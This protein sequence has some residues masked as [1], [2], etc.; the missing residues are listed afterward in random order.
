MSTIIRDETYAKC[1]TEQE[2]K[3]KWIK[4]F[5]KCFQKVFPVE[6]EE[7]VQGFPDVL[8]LT[9]GQRAVFLEFKKANKG[10]IK[11]QKSQIAF[12]RK[13][14]DLDIKVIALVENN[15]KHWIVTFPVEVLF[16]NDVFV[17]LRNNNTVNLKALCDF[18]EVGE[19]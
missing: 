14:N 19:K 4:D 15:K 13:N 3:M 10:I 2:F 6:T 11:F 5:S 18:E 7:T 8:A 16:K 17:S 1:R 9:D 12:Y